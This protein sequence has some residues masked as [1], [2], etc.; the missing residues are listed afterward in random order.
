M[1]A[2][3][4][5][6]VDVERGLESFASEELTALGAACAPAP[7]GLFVDPRGAAKRLKSLR[8]VGAV[9]RRLEFAVP[10]PKALLG[11][12]HFRRLSTVVSEVARAGG[13]FTALRIAAAGA[14]STVFRRLAEALS[15]SVGLPVD[16]T[17]GDLLLRVTPT[18]S[19]DAGGWEVLVRSTP[20]PTSTRPWRVC[21]LP[22]G[23]NATVA[24]VMNRL[25]GEADGDDYLNLMCGSGTLVIER[26]L[27]TPRAARL[28]G[29]DISPKALACARANA[30][31]A[32]AGSSARV[33]TIE[34]LEADVSE[35]DLGGSYS[36]I[37]AD[38]PWGDAVGVHADSRRLHRDLLDCAARAASENA[39]FALLTH[40]VKIA[41]DAIA[42]SR[43]WRVERSLRVSHGGH[44][45]LLAVLRRV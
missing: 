8:T 11:S 43:D 42:A 23:V 32:L 18:R 9:Y 35:L 17:G 34:W 38:A 36:A 22:G 44:N 16:Q 21:N 12:G 6:F 5:Y 15:E 30:S 14:D 39:A 3:W 29:V 45:P 28:T 40:E 7:G 10:R 31:A 4:E 1:A 20:R 41:N 37:T 33:S 24:V 27:S 13:P 25:V 2:R 19:A 26:A